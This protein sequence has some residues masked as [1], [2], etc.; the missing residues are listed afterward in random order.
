MISLKEKMNSFVAFTVIFYYFA[1]ENKASSMLTKSLVKRFIA[2][3]SSHKSIQVTVSLLWSILLERQ[4][5]VWCFL[6]LASFSAL[7]LLEQGDKAS[8]FLE[9]VMSFSVDR[10][11][12]LKPVS[13]TNRKNVL[14]GI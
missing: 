3:R 9:V 1:V 13:S 12:K 5:K 11:S 8:H 6:V 7:Q 14:I 4:C 10:E 2:P